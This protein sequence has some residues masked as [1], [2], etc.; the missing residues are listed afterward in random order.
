MD[1]EKLRKIFLSNER[2]VLVHIILFNDVDIL[3]SDWSI[4][5][6]EQSCRLSSNLQ[7]LA[8]VY[9]R[10]GKSNTFRCG[11]AFRCG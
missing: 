8:T 5:E 2:R 3:F 9:A 7:S 11:Y 1:A 4:H 10:Q 6:F